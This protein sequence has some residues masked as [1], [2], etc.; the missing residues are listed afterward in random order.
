MEEDEE[1]KNPFYFTDKGTKKSDTEIEK[2]VIDTLKNM[3]FNETEMSEELLK[4]FKTKKTLQ[5]IEE[6]KDE[7]LIKKIYYVF[8]GTAPHE[9]RN[10]FQCYILFCFLVLDTCFDKKYHFYRN[11]KGQQYKDFIDEWKRKCD[12]VV[13]YYAFNFFLLTF[14]Y[15]KPVD[16]L[17][18]QLQKKSFKD[19][20]K[21]LFQ[22]DLFANNYLEDLEGK[23][24][25]DFLDILTRA[26]QEYKNTI[27]SF[28]PPTKNISFFN[29]WQNEY[30]RTPITTEEF[31][32]DED[33]DGGKERRDEI[34]GKILQLQANIQELQKYQ[35]EAIDNAKSTP[36]ELG[37]IDLKITQYLG[38]LQDL[39]EEFDEDDEIPEDSEQRAEMLVK[40]R[41][42]M[43]EKRFRAQIV[44]LNVS[45]R[46]LKQ[47]HEYYKQLINIKGRNEEVAHQ[48]KI[49]VIERKLLKAEVKEA[50]TYELEK[51]RQELIEEILEKKKD[52]LQERKLNLESIANKKA[53]I[54][55]LSNA[56]K[57]KILET[58]LKKLIEKKQALEAEVSFKEQISKLNKDILKINRERQKE[59]KERKKKQAEED[60]RRQKEIYK[61][62]DSTRSIKEAT[63]LLRKQREKE[64]AERDLKKEQEKTIQM[65]EQQQREAEIQQEKNEQRGLL[66]AAKGGSS[67]Q[68]A[69][70]I[71]H[72]YWYITTLNA[73]STK[74]SREKNIGVLFTPSV[75][76]I[77]DQKHLYDNN[78]L[79]ADNP[80][81]KTIFSQI[82]GAG[83]IKTS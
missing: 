32:I 66:D 33:F 5:K 3:G 19:K 68:T 69:F 47:R 41:A 31:V 21:Y 24:L 81:W 77:Q 8:Y 63:A 12:E 82:R 70:Q 62:E 15:Q 34:M 2:N 54:D 78:A 46:M 76:F 52:K 23:N 7:E 59:A 79:L 55:K 4:Y 73:G 44:K 39:Q 22:Y 61:I 16:E 40:R 65:R 9:S 14:G 36:E 30:T 38:E 35:R 64:I 50:Q 80:F 20:T 17:N 72:L 13:K 18:R 43:A 10:D 11:I 48:K 57:K 83:E 45:L 49:E 42:E 27:V 71:K 6:F 53:E 60:F 29:W 37:A 75:G 26:L 67:F 25:K 51:K 74:E 56:N 1:I 28:E 58:Q